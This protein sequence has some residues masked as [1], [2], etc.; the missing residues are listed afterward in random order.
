MWP[1]KAYSW[2]ILIEHSNLLEAFG[3]DETENNYLNA[4]Q[5]VNNANNIN[6]VCPYAY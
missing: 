1:Y 3:D 6:E 2:K 5:F 4:E